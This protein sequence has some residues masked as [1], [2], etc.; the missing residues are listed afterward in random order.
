MQP[1]VAAAERATPA[2]PEDGGSLPARAGLTGG[3]QEAGS[4]SLALGSVNPTNAPT[5][6]TKGLARH[7]GTVMILA[8]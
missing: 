6:V 5:R 7:P 2:M 8:C 4:C 1:G 3:I